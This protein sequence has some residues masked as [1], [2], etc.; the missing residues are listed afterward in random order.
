[1]E[2]MTHYDNLEEQLTQMASIK[3]LMQNR[4]LEASRLLNFNVLRM[5]LVFTIFNCG[6]YYCVTQCDI[7]MIF[8]FFSLRNQPRKLL[9]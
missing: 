2:E 4:S 3:Q 7:F 8:F 9:N 1:M 6:Y 5:Y